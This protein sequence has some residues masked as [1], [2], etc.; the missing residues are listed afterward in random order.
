[1]SPTVMID[2]VTTPGAT[3]TTYGVAELFGPLIC[4]CAV[5]YMPSGNTASAAHFNQLPALI[6]I[7]APSKKETH[8]QDTAQ[9]RTE[10]NVAAILEAEYAAFVFAPLYVDEVL[11]SIV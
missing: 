8:S 2:F 11:V 5:P 3:G 4:A 6:V 1:M 7:A 9:T 10:T